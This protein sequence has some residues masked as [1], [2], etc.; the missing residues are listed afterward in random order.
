MWRRSFIWWISLAIGLVPVA[1]LSDDAAGGSEVERWKRFAAAA[2]LGIPDAE[3]EA[4]ASS[5][6]R[7]NS[8]TREALQADLGFTEPAICFRVPEGEP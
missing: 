1:V 5:L 4:I 3:I 2:G 8:A 6:E 7:L